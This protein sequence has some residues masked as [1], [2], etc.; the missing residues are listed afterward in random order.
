MEKSEVIFGTRA[1]IEAIRAGRQIEKV[2]VQTGL[3]NDLIK[4]LINETLKHGVPLSYVPAQKLNG[5]SSK[6]HQGAVCYLSA[7]QYAVL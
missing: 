1:V 7:V 6:N 3:S 4:E 2:C 5:L